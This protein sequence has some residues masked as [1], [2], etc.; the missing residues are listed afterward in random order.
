MVVK[1]AKPATIM[2]SYNKIN[3]VPATENRKTLF[4][5]L[6]ME[7]NYGG[8]VMSDW[9]AVQDRVKSLI[10]GTDLEMPGGVAHHKAQLIEAMKNGTLDN[11][12]INRACNR[13]VDLTTKLKA[14]EKPNFT[15]DHEA[16]NKLAA[17][18]ATE[19][20][21]LLKNENNALPLAKEENVCFIGSLC[22]EM[23]YQ[24]LGS[25]HVNPLR[26][27]QPLKAIK[28]Y[29]PYAYATG[30]VIDSDKE[31]PELEQKAVDLASH[32]DKVIFF[33]GLPPLYESEGF[34]RKDMKL[35]Y[36]Q[37]RLLDR[38]ISLK[39]KVVVVLFVGSPVE[40][41]FVD[42]VDGILNMYLPG[43]AGGTAVARIL[44]GEAEPSG[45]LPETWPKHLEDVPSYHFFDNDPQ[46]AEYR[47]SIYVGYRYY[48]KA[49]VEPLFPFGYG[50]SYTTF[51]YSDLDVK[52]N[53]TEFGIS[54]KVKN[55]GM[56]L[57]SEVAQLYIG[58]EDT[59][60]F[61][62]SK[63]LKRFIKIQL[64]PGEERT[65]TFTL[66]YDVFAYYNTRINE[67]VIET[68]F[69]TIM[70]GRSS[71]NILLKKQV[72][73][74]GRNDVSAAVDPSEVTSYFS[75]VGNNFPKDQFEAVLG[76][77]VPE[78]YQKLPLDENSML[79][80][81][82]LTRNGRKV[83]KLIMKI[84]NRQLDKAQ[85]MKNSDPNKKAKIRDMQLFIR[86]LP[87]ETIYNAMGN[88]GAKFTLNKAKGLLYYANGHFFKGIFYLLF[89]K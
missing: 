38:I 73:L 18:I 77:K 58:Q 44:F 1:D 60:V 66:D 10:N 43:Q 61:K 45:R 28:E 84:L 71:E 79:A 80:D 83:Y 8:V 33:A 17:K 14:N 23:R 9:G 74:N 70:I 27:I 25:S 82:K 37:L 76:R 57:G 5:I 39:K 65:I 42:E 20:A 52:D 67:Y 35:P 4:E 68:G 88:A 59:G 31:I 15:C 72:R 81:F 69:A 47:E 13:I 64:D 11:G 30:Y 78:N 51:E 87:N 56:R 53:D 55:T 54:F 7:W 6:R 12:A 19:G 24:G 36:N 86:I 41:P 26:L 3:G 62:T 16:H 85:K 21:V 46:K 29:G 48:D 50:L 34:D 2:A 22:E 75:L 89:K 63:Q 40:L 32:S 49:K